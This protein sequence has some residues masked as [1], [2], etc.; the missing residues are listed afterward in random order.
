MQDRVD[1]LDDAVSEFRT[2]IG[3]YH[4]LV[5]GQPL[6]AEPLVVIQLVRAIVLSL[7]KAFKDVLERVNPALVFAS[8]SRDRLISLERER[9]AGSFPSILCTRSSERTVDIL[10]AWRTARQC[11]LVGEDT[12]LAEAEVAFDQALRELVDLRNRA[13]HSVFLE[14]RESVRNTVEQLLANFDVVCRAYAPT[15]LERLF[16]ADD[17]LQSVLAGAADSI[18]GRWRVIEDYCDQHGAVDLQF[19]LDVFRKEGDDSCYVQFGGSRA[20]IS[21]SNLVGRALVQDPDATGLFTTSLSTALVE[22]RKRRRSAISKGKSALSLLDLLAGN[23]AEIGELPLDPGT[24]FIRRAS[25]HLWLDLKERRSRFVAVAATSLWHV[26]LPSED[27]PGGKVF[28]LLIPSYRKDRAAFRFA[29]FEG[30][31]SHA[32]EAAADRDE[33][34]NPPTPASSLLSFDVRGRISLAVDAAPTADA[35]EGEPA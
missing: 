24:L 22:D 27:T 35:G 12:R 8:I 14:E 15:F 32:S 18:D 34:T 7:E 2:A 29:K 5:P 9:V 11:T 6:E 3:K 19:S 31:V 33:T 25:C 1:L 20:T 16:E 17:Q 26:S 10:D 23:E 13:Q 28:G 4:Q 30:M 21:L